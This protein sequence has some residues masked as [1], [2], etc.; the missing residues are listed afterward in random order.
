MKTLTT[1]KLYLETM[2]IK[3]GRKNAEGSP[4]PD[5]DLPP[6][7]KIKKVI[8][9]YILFGNKELRKVL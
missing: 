4:V 7:N 5:M 1:K 2:M 8:Y 3:K 9:N 6:K